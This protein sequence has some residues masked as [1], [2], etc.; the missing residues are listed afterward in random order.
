MAQT[1]AKI[2]NLADEIGDREPGDPSILRASFPV[3]QVARTA[4]TLLGAQAITIGLLAE[5]IV[6]NTGRD[7]DT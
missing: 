7:S 3:R 5:L 4:S 6:Y 2:L 1:A